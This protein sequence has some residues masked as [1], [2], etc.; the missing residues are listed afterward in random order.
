M[1]KN[2]HATDRRKSRSPLELASHRGGAAAVEFALLAV[3]LLALIFASLQTAVIFFADQSLQTVAQQSARQ[4]M[5]GNAQ[6]ASMTQAQF[7]TAVCNNA[8]SFFNCANLMVDVESSGS[9]SSVSTTP[10]T[11]TYNA[12]GAVTNTWSYS[13]GAAGDI[14]IARVMYNWP[15]FGGPLALG[16]ANQSN[17]DHLLVATVVFKNEP[18][19]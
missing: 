14:V 16:L 17:G 19:E 9:F 6:L 15:V 13:P 12:Q 5:T 10:L 8:P 7:A 4:L 18:Y 11:V 2:I 1:R 3:P